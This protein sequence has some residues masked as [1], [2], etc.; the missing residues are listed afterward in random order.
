MKKAQ[1]PNIAL[2]KYGAGHCNFSCNSISALVWGWTLSKK[3]FGNFIIILLLS[4]APGQDNQQSPRTSPMQN[5]RRKLGSDKNGNFFIHGFDS[6]NLLSLLCL[7]AVFLCKQVLL[8]PLLWRFN[9]GW[10]M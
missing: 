4:I 3:H 5:V 2:A 6:I 10:T 1:T 9:C 7:D 8:P